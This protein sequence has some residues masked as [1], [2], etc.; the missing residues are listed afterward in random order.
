MNMMHTLSKLHPQVTRNH[1]PWPQVALHW[2]RLLE[3]L[4]RYSDGNTTAQ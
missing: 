1:R 4:T 3:V 2:L